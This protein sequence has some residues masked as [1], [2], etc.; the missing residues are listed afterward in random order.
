MSKLEI[1]G[2][3]TTWE[4]IKYIFTFLIIIARNIFHGINNFVHRFPWLC[5]LITI[6]V[7]FIVSFVNI[8][9]ARAE[10][11]CYNKKNVQLTEKVASYEA[12]FGKN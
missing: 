2:H 4:A 8:S 9:K 11:D 5:I 6:I 3:V 12:A 1:K 10:R 7:A